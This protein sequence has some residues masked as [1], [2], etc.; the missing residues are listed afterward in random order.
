[1]DD[2]NQVIHLDPQSED[3]Y[4]SRGKAWFHLG[5]LEFARIDFQNYLQR[6]PPRKTKLEEEEYQWVQE[7]FPELFETH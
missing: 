3:G 5:N 6:V 4:Y 2:C 1:M 7:R